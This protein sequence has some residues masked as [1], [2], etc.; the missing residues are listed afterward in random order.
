MAG[1]LLPASGLGGPGAWLTA[2][3]GSP[4]QDVLH[5]TGGVG[6]GDHRSPR[7]C[8]TG[9]NKRPGARRTCP[10]VTCPGGRAEEHG[11]PPGSEG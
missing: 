2:P 3:S 11:G 4:A 9:V 5:L 1:T 8:V 6:W 10:P 7:Q